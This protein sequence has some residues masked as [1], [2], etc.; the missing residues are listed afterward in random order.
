MPD[1]HH[2]ELLMSADQQD[3]TPGPILLFGSGETS[4]SGQ[5]AFE[6]LFR[7]LPQSPKIT[8][9]ET[10]AGFEPNSAAVAGKLGSFIDHHL[11]NYDPQVQVLPA[12]KLGSP[13]SPDNPDVVAPIYDADVIFLGPGSPSYAVRQLRDTQAWYG[14]VARHHLGAALVLASAGVIAFSAYSLPVYEIYKVGEDLHWKTGLDYFSIFQ[15]PLV[16]IPHWDNSE[17]GDKLDTSRCYMG[18]E[19]FRQ[20]VAK[21]PAGLTIVGLDEHTALYMDPAANICK[22][23]GKSSVTLIHTGEQH[24]GALADIDLRGTGLAEIARMKGGHVHIFNSGEAFDLN[25]LGPFQPSTPAEHLPPEVWQRALAAQAEGERPPV[26]P[27]T[28]Q[29]LVEQREVARNQ[30]DWNQADALRQEIID[31]GWQVMDT[32]DGPVLEKISVKA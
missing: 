5:R 24:P 15:L 18:R 12:R 3:H 22:V 27:P 11:Q 16:F 2:P 19:R 25:R 28:V 31:S 6:H 9:L 32:P 30:R 4:P 17:G 20:L 14:M 21:L 23:L 7:Q 8:I 26:V 1:D 29:A 13:D 10:P